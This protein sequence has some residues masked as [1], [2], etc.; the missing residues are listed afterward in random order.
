MHGHG[1]WTVVAVLAVASASA[2]GKPMSVRVN[3]E[4]CTAEWLQIGQ[5]STNTQEQIRSWLAVAEKCARSGLYE[6]RLALL[7]VLD[8]RLDDARTAIDTGLA[9]KTPYEKELTSVLANVEMGEGKLDDSLQRYERLIRIYPKFFDAYAGAGAVKVLQRRFSEAL[10]YLSEAR[11]LGKTA[12]MY[13]NLI[14]TYDQLGK[15]DAAVSAVK[16]GYAFDISIGRDKEAMHAAAIAYCHLGNFSVADGMLK[17]L[18]H[19]D[20]EAAKDP[21]VARTMLYISKHLK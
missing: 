3:H 11:A 4:S 10:T 13:R 18:F 16:E 7:Y 20:P 6:A 12:A 21:E 15:Y 9:L 2:S 19:A 8:G 14:V 1:H 17:M 5:G